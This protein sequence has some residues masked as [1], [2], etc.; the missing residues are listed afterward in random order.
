MNLR[1][2]R[3]IVAFP[4]SHTAMPVRSTL[5]GYSQHTRP[6]PHVSEAPGH[7]GCEW[8]AGLGNQRWFLS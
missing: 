2:P 5:A 1:L 6:S 4:S 3:R 8:E 7:E